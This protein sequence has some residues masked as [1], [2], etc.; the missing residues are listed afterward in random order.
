MI[1]VF[2]ARTDSPSV[3]NIKSLLLTQESQIENKIVND[4]FLSTV[5]VTTQ[6]RGNQSLEK[7]NEVTNRGSQNN[8][9]YTNNNS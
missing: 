7:E 8:F 1:L 4:V 6:N 9:Q 3:Q 5:N 2:F